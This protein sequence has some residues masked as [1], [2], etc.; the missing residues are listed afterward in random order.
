MRRQQTLVGEWRMVTRVYDNGHVECYLVHR[1]VH[2][3]NFGAELTSK[4]RLTVTEQELMDADWDA[5]LDRALGKLI[6]EA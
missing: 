3:S 1:P 2:N 5:L 6:A 4:C